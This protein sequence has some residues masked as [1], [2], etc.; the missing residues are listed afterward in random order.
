MVEE[1]AVNAVEKKIGPIEGIPTTVVVDRQ[2][3]IKYVHVGYADKA[4]FEKIIKKYL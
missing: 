3:N 4:E 1:L 2:G